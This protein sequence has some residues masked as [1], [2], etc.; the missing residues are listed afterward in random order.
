MELVKFMMNRNKELS[1][2]RCK[3]DR[4]PVQ[5]A[6]LFGHEKIVLHLYKATENEL[7][8]GD[9]SEL[10]VTLI[11]NSL[12]DTALQLLQQHGELA[13]FRD[14]NGETALHALA[15]KPL[16]LSDL[17]NPNQ[18]GI[19]K[20]FFKQAGM[21]RTALHL[22]EL[23]WEK[24]ILLDDLQISFLIGT[25]WKLIFFAAE[26][27]N[28]ELLSKLIY[29]YPDLLIKVNEDGHTILHIAVMNR[30]DR[31]FNLINDIGLNKDSIVLKQ[32]REENNILHLAAKLPPKNQLNA[33][34][35]A[36]LQMQRELLW[37]KEVSKLMPPSK[38]VAKNQSRKTAHDLFTESHAMLMKE[39]EVWM[40][41]TAESCML[42][43]T[44]IATVVFAAAFTVPGSVKE[45]TGVPHFLKKASF[46][47]FAISDTISLVSSSCSILTFLSILTARYAEE[48]FLWSLPIKLLLG[49]STLFISIAAMMV[50]F[51]ATLFIVFNDQILE[52]IVLAVALA[53]I[54]V[55][56]FILQHTR[57]FI[58]VVRLMSLSNSLFNESQSSFLLF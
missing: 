33:V 34:S 15:R 56:M 32:D 9:R 13:T 7:T 21:H 47:I 31:I 29:G 48:D 53:C 24:I 58:D 43:A 19:L 40:K 12:Y 55:V 5:I 20:R 44:L 16:T 50:V 57:L 41:K 26:H 36:A 6:A 45:D 51:C 27:G 35:G 1:V 39:G 8:D 25:P 22:V 52:T 17:V 4:L 11:D 38:F 54:P 18:Q 23:L 46:K 2:I 30:H 37:F 49:L 10:L 42:V 28:H 14:G 3:E